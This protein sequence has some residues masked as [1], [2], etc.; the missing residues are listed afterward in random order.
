M[1]LRMALLGLLVTKGPASGYA[2]TK[3]F[4]H[5]LAHV[6]SAQHS[7]VYPELARM[8]RA[9]LITVENE[10]PRGQKQY[11]VTET[12]RTELR[13]WLTEV[14]PHRPVRNEIALRAF[15]MSTLPRET[16]AELA[17]REVEF[18]RERVAEL[19]AL[20][21]ALEDGPGF[22]YYA[23]EYGVRVSAAVEGWAQWAVEQMENGAHPESSGG[24]T[25]PADGA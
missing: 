8:A 4:T 20:R 10:G 14:P 25:P 13:R 23:A 15:L 1:S 21:D 16:A 19:T 7:Q 2:L 11:S 3:S 9:E 12:G 24:T 17:R 22:G 5:S 6:W 18:H